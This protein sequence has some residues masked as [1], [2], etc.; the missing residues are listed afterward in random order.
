MIITSLHG[1]LT[2]LNFFLMAFNW[3][4]FKTRTL[5][6]AVFVIV[7]LA[8]LLI[9]RWTFFI[10][11]SVIH[12]GC[13]WEYLGLVEKIY[14]NPFH[15]YFKIGLMLIGYGMMAWI[16]L[17]FYYTEF[18]FRELIFTIIPFIGYGLLIFGFSRT[19]WNNIRAS[20]VALLGLF[21]ISL[22]L[23]LML[24]L[25]GIGVDASCMGI[26]G[27]VGVT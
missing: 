4:T 1:S 18:A 7:M 21:Y 20:R 26:G 19:Q 3:Q 6:A 8:G 27:I 15:K 13:W 17:L 24:T 14:K 25:W 11:F 2:V 23:G 9:N 5:T 22:S 10:L 16:N 12:F